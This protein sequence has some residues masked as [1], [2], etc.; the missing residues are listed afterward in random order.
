M[1]EIQR[2]LET[3]RFHTVPKNCNAISELREALNQ[4]IKYWGA[5]YLHGE[6]RQDARVH[7]ARNADAHWKAASDL[8]K[9]NK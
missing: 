1:S 8:F 6:E 3:L 7:H 4:E 2:A 9:E 5:D